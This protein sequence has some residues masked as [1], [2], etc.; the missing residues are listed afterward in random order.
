MVVDVVVAAA[1]AVNLVACGVLL[2]ACSALWLVLVL[3]PAAVWLLLLLLHVL[4][5]CLAAPTLLPQPSV[6]PHY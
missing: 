5:A 4:L 2:I 1:C 6:R 3:L